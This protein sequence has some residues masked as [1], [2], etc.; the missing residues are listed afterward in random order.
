MNCII[1]NMNYCFILKQIFLN[2]IF[3]SLMIICISIILY[4][5]FKWQ[6]RAWKIKKFNPKHTINAIFINKERCISILPMIVKEQTYYNISKETYCVDKKA[7]MN[8]Y[9]FK[10]TIQ[11]IGKELIEYS[12]LNKLPKNNIMEQKGK[13]LQDIEEYCIKE[14][15]LFH[16]TH[17]RNK[18]F[19]KQN[20]GE[21]YSLY[22]DGNPNPILVEWLLKQT[23]L[24]HSAEVLYYLAH[25]NFFKQFL[26]DTNKINMKTI[27]IFIGIACAIIFLIW[28]TKQNGGKLI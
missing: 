6:I 14:K 16:T 7:I 5:K 18:I 25:Q 20:I 4:L 2:W 22:N 13:E 23:G 3:I 8:K 28:Y 26:T 24:K 19:N 1:G 12:Q 11:Q 27:L 10:K 15:A 21:A 9:D 17:S